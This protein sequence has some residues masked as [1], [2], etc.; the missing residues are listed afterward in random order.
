MVDQRSTFAAAD[1]V[2]AVFVA[3]GV[4]VVGGGAVAI[5]VP[6]FTDY[7]ETSVV[8]VEDRTTTLVVW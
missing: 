2:A 6:V 8:A 7:D 5:V 3:V 4:G 1:V